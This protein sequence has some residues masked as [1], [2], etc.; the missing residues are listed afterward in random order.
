MEQSSISEEITRKSASN[1]A[2]AFVMLPADKRAAMS[3]LYAYCREVDDVADEDEIPVEDRREQLADWR[4]QT[5]SACNGGDV[6][7]PVVREL[8]PAIRDYQLPWQLFDDLLKGVEA[9]LDQTRYDTYA[10]LEQYCYRVASAVGL[11]SIRI[12]GHRNDQC[13]EYALALGKALQFTNILRDVGNDATRDRIYLPGEALREFEV[14]EDQI[15][16]GDYTPGFFRLAES[17]AARAKEHFRSARKLLPPEDRR[18]MIAAEL[19]GVV[20]WRLLQRLEADGYHVL[21]STPTK[22]SKPHK[23]SIILGIWLRHLLGLNTSRYGD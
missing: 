18:S 11:L 22:L 9:D 21:A 12:F 10:D 14:T 6:T 2:L 19:M 23:L 8:V 17:F 16:N 13:R 7:L 4:A 1:L 5:L 3:A 20:Y 15:L